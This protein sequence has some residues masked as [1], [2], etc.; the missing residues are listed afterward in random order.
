ME[1]EK[2]PG[3]SLSGEAD[4]PLVVGGVSAAGQAAGT[5]LREDHG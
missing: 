3:E 2:N 1:A 4:P 5:C